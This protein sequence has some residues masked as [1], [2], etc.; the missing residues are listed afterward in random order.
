MALRSGRAL[1]ALGFAL[2]AALACWNP[3]AA[4]FGMLVGLS[5]GFLSIRAL[6]RGGGRPIAAAALALSVAAVAGSGLV[7]AV[8]AG[9]GRDPT[10][11]PVVSG[12]SGDEAAKALDEAAE[13]TRAARERAREELRRAAGEPAEA[14]GPAA[15]KRR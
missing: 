13:R 1:A 9:V 11:E 12:P 2:A 7:L 5:A 10:G 6:R 15:G 8:T 14:P 4:P 3:L